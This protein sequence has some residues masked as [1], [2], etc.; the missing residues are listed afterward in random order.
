[1]DID[2]NICVDMDMYM[3]KKENLIK[4]NTPTKDKEH[5][6]KNI[7]ISGGAHTI[8]QFVGILQELEKNA[9]F[10]RTKIE[11][12]Y[13]VSAGTIISVVLCLDFD[14]ET[15]ND[16]FIKRPWSEVFKF[17]INTLFNTYHTKG[18]Y[19]TSAFETV[20]KP[21]FDAKDI[22]LTVTMHEFYEL[23]KK[24][25]H[26]YAVEINAFEYE[27][28]SFKTYPDLPLMTAI[29]MSCG[30]PLLIV[31]VCMD[32]K[33]FIDGGAYCNYP[34]TFCLDDGNLKEETLGIKKC[35]TQQTEKALC[36]TKDSTLV[37]YITGIVASIIAQVSLDKKSI[38]SQH[39]Y[40][41]RIKNE[42]LCYSDEININIMYDVASSQEKRKELLDNGIECACQFLDEV[43][44]NTS[45]SIVTTL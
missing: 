15:I 38:V 16:Y 14:W 27:D 17:N 35:R 42:I 3:D 29:Q 7:V 11:K 34:L 21:L 6:I 30:L 41:K 40:V 9:F 12:L 45:I 28:I 39:K 24:E 22:P 32:G 31:P 44:T 13:A 2:K 25:I 19:D 23:T 1:M 33:C 10:D 8:F 26:F 20:F 37:E 36:I 4:D 5:T 43:K 18:I